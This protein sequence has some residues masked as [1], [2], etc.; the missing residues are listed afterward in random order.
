MNQSS[1]SRAA[2]LK[3][4]QERARRR[5]PW[6]LIDPGLHADIVAGYRAVRLLFFALFALLGHPLRS[7]AS[8]ESRA[9]ETEILQTE[10]SYDS[11]SR[12]CRMSDKSELM[13]EKHARHL[14]QPVKLRFG[15]ENVRHPQLI[16]LKIYRAHAPP[17]GQIP[18][19]ITAVLHPVVPRLYSFLRSFP[20]ALKRVFALTGS[21]PA[22]FLTPLHLQH[23]AVITVAS[24]HLCQFRTKGDNRYVCC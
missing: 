24:P 20:A 15:I 12:S 6:I 23:S 8:T 13:A 10:A 19:E 22:I 2:A 18:D 11:R 3:A 14:S 9:T 7:Q 1:N 4:I 16:R 5:T 17:R 21:A